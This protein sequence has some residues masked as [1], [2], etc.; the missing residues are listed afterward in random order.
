MLPFAPMA[1]ATA[2]A[3]LSAATWSRYVRTRG[4]A[5]LDGDEDEREQHDAAHGEDDDHGA[6]LVGAEATGAPCEAGETT[7]WGEAEGGMKTSEL[8][9]FDELC[10]TSHTKTGSVP[11]G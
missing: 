3:P 1:L 11:H 8:Q 10:E 2:S 7:R 5:V 6:A 9:R 4:L